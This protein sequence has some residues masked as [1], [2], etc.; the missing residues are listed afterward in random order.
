MEVKNSF[1]EVLEICRKGL[2]AAILRNKVIANNIAN[3]D[4]PNFKRQG[5]EFEQSLR[6]LLNRDLKFIEFRAKITDIRHIK[7]GEIET[8]KELHPRPFVE[9]DTS[10]RNDLNNVDLNEE[11][12][13]LNKNTILY[14]SIVKIL[15][16]E[17][18]GLRSI[19]TRR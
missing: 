1:F 5:V 17:F 10:Y 19:I 15:T 7:F 14:N 9:Y 4:T 13:N 12:A 11:I 2:Q 8:I 3:V 18:T 6:R 16:S